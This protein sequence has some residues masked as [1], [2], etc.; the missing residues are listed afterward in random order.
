[1]GEWDAKGA[2][3]QDYQRFAN[4]QLQVF[5]KA[6]FGWAFWTFKNVN[7]HISLQWMITN[8]YITLPE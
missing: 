8:G 2:S 4:A 6:T 3:K 1:M 5:G 7:N